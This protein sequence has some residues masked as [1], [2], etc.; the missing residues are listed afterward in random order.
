L[1]TLNDLGHQ[2]IFTRPAYRIAIALPVPVEFH[3]P[4]KCFVDS[5]EKI[6]VH[7]RAA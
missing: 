6:V 7:I 5:V 4:L 1:Q 3:Q 2:T